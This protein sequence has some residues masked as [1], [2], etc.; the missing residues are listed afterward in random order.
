MNFASL[1]GFGDVHGG[2]IGTE[3]I[4]QRTAAPGTPGWATHG[5]TPTQQPLPIAGLVPPNLDPAY[6]ELSI[7]L[8]AGVF[9][10][11]RPITDAPNVAGLLNLYVRRDLRVAGSGFFQ[12]ISDPGFSVAP[13]PAPQL[14]RPYV[15]G[16]S[17]DFS[18]VAF[19]SRMNL[20]P[21]A[22]GFGP[23]LYESVDGTVR[24]AGVLPDGTPAPTSQ[25]G[26]GSMAGL[27]NQHMISADG[28]RVFFRAPAGGGDIYVRVN[29]ATTVQLNASEKS[30]PEA[31][32][33]AVPWT[34][35][36]DGRRVFFSTNEGLVDGDDDGADDYYMY[37]VDAAAGHHLTL[38]SRDGEPSLVDT[39]LG[40]VGASDDGHYL[41]FM[42]SGQL[43]AGE[44]PLVT[45][46]YVWHDGAVRFIGAFM[47]QFNFALNTL[48]S[49]WLGGD[50]ATR[51]R[52]A[53][54]GTH[55]AFAATDGEGFRGRGG[56]SGY[57]HGTA[58]DGSG[59]QEL[60]VYGA[61]DGQLRCASCNP[62]GAPPTASM[63]VNTRVD[64]YASALS[65]TTYLN[66]VLSADGRWVFFNSKDALVPEDVNGKFDAYGYDTA[67][68]EVFLLSSGRSTDDSY[69]LDSSASG[70][71]AFFVTRERLVGWD[72]D[73]NY[74]LYDARVGGGFPD[75]AAPAPPCVGD[76]CQSAPQAPSTA[77]TSASRGFKGKGDARGTLAPRHAKHKRCARGKRRV[78]RRGKVRCVRRTARRSARSRAKGGVGR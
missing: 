24:L 65:S 72:S 44:D 77:D 14:M 35:S 22:S 4:A 32:Q 55:V 27:F 28:T 25:A 31:P 39:P 53:A 62:S 23:K 60:Y 8:A 47:E 69:F 2:T 56:F 66:R 70:R 71:D 17:S 49:F 48:D 68:D 21:G 7:D 42:M 74:D 51:A 45:G 33:P 18:H 30:T 15:V 43:V 76:A 58:C 75:P 26:R 57:D 38:V 10:A 6:D 50:L 19:E 54:D 37:E 64:Q 59:C 63:R 67:N 20:A 73:G 16:A 12:L 41:Y 61:V 46:I 1:T 40:V 36:A 9:R 5:I 29:G 78:V 52:V 13:L 3:F 11:Y 34:A